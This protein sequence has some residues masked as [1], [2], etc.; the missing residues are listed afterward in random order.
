MF[1]TRRSLRQA[2]QLVSLLKLTFRHFPGGSLVIDAG[3]VA[4]NSLKILAIAL[5]S[6]LQ[7]L[8]LR[9]TPS[10]FYKRLL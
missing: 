2:Y 9:R 1:N 7:I 5:A 10:M 6:L 3:Q 8:E 4:G